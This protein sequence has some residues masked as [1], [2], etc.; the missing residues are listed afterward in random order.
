MGSE[1][2]VT[3][4]EKVLKGSL[5][6]AIL[7]GIFFSVPGFNA[8]RA[9]IF[10]CDPVS[11]AGDIISDLADCRSPSPVPCISD[12]RVPGWVCDD[13]IAIVIGD[14]CAKA[15]SGELISRGCRLFVLVQSDMDIAG[16]EVVRIPNGMGFAASI[17][18]VLGATASIITSA[19]IFDA[20]DALSD[21]MDCIR[22]FETACAGVAPLS[23][24]RPYAFYSTSDIHAAAKLCRISFTAFAGKTAFCGEL[25]EFDHNELVG[26]SDAN[27]HAPELTM[28][29]VRGD[30]GDGIVT[31][32]VDSML[33]VL[34]ENGRSVMVYDVPGADAAAKDCNALLLGIALAGRDA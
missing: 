25:P 19:G 14:T 10:G 20:V 16:A 22:E 18:F 33:E 23:S 1:S 15:L 12:F 27:A 21:D 26:W 31:D 4:N 6:D 24:G 5:S 7:S 8:D 32:I 11:L 34:S 30:N 13:V 17:G 2:D 3:S 28:V 29:V 9:C